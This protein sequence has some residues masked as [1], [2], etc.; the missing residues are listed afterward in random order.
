MWLAFSEVLYAM[1]KPFILCPPFRF[2]SRWRGI[3]SICQG[4]Q[5][6]G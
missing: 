3:L 6:N 4:L 1:E 2:V 5:P